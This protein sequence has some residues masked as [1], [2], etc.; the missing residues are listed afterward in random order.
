MENSE[1]LLGENSDYIEDLFG[2][3]VQYQ[4]PRYQR[5]YVWDIGNWSTLW[6]DILFQLNL[7]PFEPPDGGF[8]ASRAHFTGLIVTRPISKGKLNRF[9]VIDGQ[10]RL[11]TFQIVLSV[12][13][14][15]CES[16]G[17]S[18][19]A[20]EVDGHI[21]NTTT[22]IRRNTLEFF[23]DPTYKF[24]PT[25]YDES[26]FRAV[27]QGE[28][29]KIIPEAFDETN[30]HLKPIFVREVRSKIFED[31]KDVSPNILD[32]YDYFYERIWIYVGKDCNY[33]KADNFVSSIKSGF[34]LI[35]ITLS[36][37]DQ[38]EE[39]FESLN[40]TGRKL[41]EFDYLRNNLF[42]RAGKLGV[43]EESDRFYSDIFYDEYWHFEN[44]A[45]YWDADRLE[46]FLRTFLVAK[47]GPENEEKPLKAF[48]R[49]KSYSKTLTEEHQQNVRYEFEQL[50]CYA[51]SYQAMSDP[52]SEIGKQM[53]F[54]DYLHLPRLDSFVLFLK[55]GLELKPEELIKVCRM[56]ES[57]IM[58]GML[59]YGDW[60]SCYQKINA[61]FTEAMEH[62]T[63]NVSE[64]ETSLSDGSPN[65]REVEFALK[66]A[67]SKEESLI[68]YILYRIEEMYRI[69]ARVQRTS[70]DFKSLNLLYIEHRQLP[71][72]SAS[73]EEG[74]IWWI[75]KDSIGNIT[76][77]TSGPPQ[78][79][80]K[81]TFTAKKEALKSQIA[82]DL[83]LTHG[84]CKY[85]NW[86]S[87]QIDKRAGDLLSDLSKIW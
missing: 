85:N 13:R 27:V 30:N 55:H 37:S 72:S 62:Q 19:L 80:D 29:G 18:E 67:G 50:K 39:I 47:L 60:K 26:A 75:E 28:Y 53:Q 73:D 76:L 71:E 40:A 56:L 16:K 11:T 10:Q 32:A 61:C 33:D 48:D 83:L 58:R 22:V 15:I 79:W 46:L 38:S 8:A 5:R 70:L 14:D 77:Q 2:T 44:A 36:A 57:Y 12:I 78:D 54:Y 74:V 7:S 3:A 87:T 21:V 35:H 64:F 82:P 23:P 4:V 20:E 25:D 42:L 63:F 49:Y 65:D 17:H 1:M 24:R 66:S 45:H 9:E 43:D 69:E 52:A 41:S 51:D 59:C 68:S 84:I 31:P 81:L 6:T 34:N 86:T